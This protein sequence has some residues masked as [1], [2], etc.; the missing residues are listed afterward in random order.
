MIEF[1][2]EKGA[3]VDVGV[4][5]DG[6][7]PKHSRAIHVAIGAVSPDA[8]EALRALLR[9]GANPDAKNAISCTAL[10]M[11]CRVNRDTAQ[12]VS[13][14]RELLAVGAD[15]NLRDKDGRVALHYAAFSENLELI[16]M[17]LSEPSLSTLNHIT[18][19]GKTPLLVAVE[20]NHPAVLAGLS[21]RGRASLPRW[22]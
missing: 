15:V 7:F 11:A 19:V 22:A 2:L 17:L 8:L 6:D 10:M 9:A 14:A 16:D 21:P 18:E 3:D 1:F 12:C 4:W 5:R 20:F 13:M